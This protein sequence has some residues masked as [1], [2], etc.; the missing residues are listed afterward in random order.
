[1]INFKKRFT[2][3]YNLCYH[4]QC[5]VY[6]QKYVREGHKLTYNL[7][8]TALDVS[9]LRQET[10]SSN[11]SNINTPDYKANRVAFESYFD[12]ALNGTRLNRTHENHVIGHQKDQIIH[13]QEDTFTQD[14]GNNVDIDFEMSELSANSIYYD[15]VVSQLNAKYAMMRSAIQ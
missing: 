3:G 8:K 13:R 4:R 14:N 11:I 9:N 10:I 1:M 6:C 5:N 15:A 12:Q 7:L 2:K